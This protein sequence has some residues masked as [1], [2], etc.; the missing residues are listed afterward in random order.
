LVFH[1]QGEV[2]LY[3]TTVSDPILSYVLADNCRYS[4]IWFWYR[5]QFIRWKDW[6]LKYTYKGLFK[7]LFWRLFKL[8]G[9][10]LVAYATYLRRTSDV[11]LEDLLDNYKT[12]AV[13][14]ALMVVNKTR[15]RL[16][17]ML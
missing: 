6:N 12:I 3:R 10:A 17:K 9:F 14:S 16:L 2:E 5:T 15:K 1:R 13:A 7:L 11:P 4:Q 8:L